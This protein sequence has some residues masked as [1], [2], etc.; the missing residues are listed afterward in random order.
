VSR[1]FQVGEGSVPVRFSLFQHGPTVNSTRSVNLRFPGLSR[2][3]GGFSARFPFP[4]LLPQSSRPPVVNPTFTPPLGQGSIGLVSSRAYAPGTF[5]FLEARPL[6][7]GVPMNGIRQEHPD[8]EYST[9]LCIRPSLLGLFARPHRLL[10]FWAPKNVKFD[11]PFLP[12]SFLRFF[13]FPDGLGGAPPMKDARGRGLPCCRSHSLLTDRL[14]RP[15]WEAGARTTSSGPGSR[16]CPPLQGT[17][18][19]VPRHV[20]ADSELLDRGSASR[21]SP[22][23]CNEL[24]VRPETTPPLT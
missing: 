17:Q 4:L 14:S 7:N 18:F 5:F 6:S 8:T 3:V 20:L 9:C 10:V 2:T 22:F 16:P 19:S 15:N 24:A 23:F 1:I 11:R 12:R 13:F 21:G